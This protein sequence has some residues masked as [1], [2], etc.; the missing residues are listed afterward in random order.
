MGFWIGFW[1]VLFWL[2]LVIF[3]GVAVKV[4]VGGVSDIRALFR[5]IDAQHEDDG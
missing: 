3:V 5:S 4:A 1:T 2:A